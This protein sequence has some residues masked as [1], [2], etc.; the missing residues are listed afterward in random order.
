MIKHLSVALTLAAVFV[1]GLA[2][3]DPTQAQRAAQSQPPAVHAMPYGPGCG[4]P[5]PPSTPV[6]STHHAARPLSTPR[7]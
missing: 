3:A 7:R 5:R 1:S 2:S 6:Q 4:S